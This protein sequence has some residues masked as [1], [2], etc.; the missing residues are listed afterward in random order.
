MYEE[1]SIVHSIVESKGQLADFLLA[2]ELRLETPEFNQLMNQVS[3]RL[4]HQFAKEQD[5]FV[6]VSTSI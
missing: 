3:K 4:E 5:I 1:R 2:D 6:A